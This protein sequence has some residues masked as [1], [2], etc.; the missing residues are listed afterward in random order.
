MKLQSK[1]SVVGTATRYGLDGPGIESPWDEFFRDVQTSTWPSQ[2]PVKWVPG[3]FKG[4]GGSKVAL[5]C[6]DYLHNSSVGLRMRWSYTSS[7]PTVGIDF[8]I[9]YLYL[10]CKN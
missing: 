5:A 8:V 2:P 9:G 10:Y 3:L 4:G 1:L 7:S 6:A